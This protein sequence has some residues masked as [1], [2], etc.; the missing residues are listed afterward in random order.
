MENK[1][2]YGRYRIVHVGKEEYLGLS[3]TGLDIYPPPPAPV[4][5]LPPDVL[6]P[7][8]TIV[9]VDV[10]ANTYVIL[11]E[12]RVTRGQDNRVFA[13]VNEPAEVWRIRYNEAHDAYS[14]EKRGEFGPGLSLGWT[15]VIFVDTVNPN[16]ITLQQFS[17]PGPYQLF[18]FERVGVE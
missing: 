1:L 13:F 7:E 5:V 17:E 9:P 12:K 2:V 3:N 14:I 16:Q 8:F 10:E 6:P 15:L 11:V 4:I 18:K